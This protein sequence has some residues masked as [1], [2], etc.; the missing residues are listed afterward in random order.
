[1]TAV[2][3]AIPMLPA[4]HAA[5]E[6]ATTPILELACCVCESEKITAPLGSTPTTRF[7]CCWCSARIWRRKQTCRARQPV[8]A[9]FLIGRPRVIPF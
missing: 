3:Q 8:D 1:V 9:G 6:A 4:T 5:P 7:V 2:F